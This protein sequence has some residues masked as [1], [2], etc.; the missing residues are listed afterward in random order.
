[1]TAAQTTTWDPE[2][3]YG[4]AVWVAFVMIQA[5]DGLLTYLGMHLHGI[6]AEAN[7]LIAWYAATYGITASVLSAK[8]FATMCGAILHVGDR[9]QI[10]AILTLAYG[11]VA[12]WPWT[13]VLWP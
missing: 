3:I 13:M 9:H 5:A 7:P 11:G 1:M 8:I 4:N 10:L 12:V 6:G 2:R